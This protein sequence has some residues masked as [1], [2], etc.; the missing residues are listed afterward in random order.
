MKTVKITVTYEAKVPNNFKIVELR[1]N[2]DGKLI[3]TIPALKVGKKLA[4][5]DMIFFNYKENTDGTLEGFQDD[6]LFD[7]MYSFIPS[8]DS[9]IEII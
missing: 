6:E 3:P 4:V 1:E 9:K 8:I 2:V 7:K 5:P